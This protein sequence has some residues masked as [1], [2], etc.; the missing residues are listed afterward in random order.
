MRREKQALA[1]ELKRLRAAQHTP[2]AGQHSA[3]SP[4]RSAAADMLLQAQLAGCAVAPPQGPCAASAVEEVDEVLALL[5]G[6]HLERQQAAAAPPDTAAGHSSA[7]ARGGGAAAETAPADAVGTGVPRSPPVPR[8]SSLGTPPGSRPA[9]A[10][11]ALKPAGRTM[12]RRASAA[13]AAAAA[14]HVSA[15]ALRKCRSSAATAGTRQQQPK[16]TGADRLPDTARQGQG[17]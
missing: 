12:C 17:H 3:S 13:A 14:P 8:S 16:H 6:C 5:R 11:A 9:P 10:Q 15:T 4:W 7:A 1:Q 2:L